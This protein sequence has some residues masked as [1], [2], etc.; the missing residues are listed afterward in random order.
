MH[1][2]PFLLFFIVEVIFI[3][4][5]SL[6]SFLLFLTDS[7]AQSE[8]RRLVSWLVSNLWMKNYGLTI[9]MKS[10]LALPC[11]SFRYYLFSM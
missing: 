8:R 1:V 9:Q 5:L 7:L 2:E 10:R 4:Q 3:R 6:I 11:S